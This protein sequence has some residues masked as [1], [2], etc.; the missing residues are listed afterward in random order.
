[1]ALQASGQIKY[2]EIIAEFGTSNSGGIGEYRLSESVGT[3]TN[4]PLDIGVPQTGQIKFSDF[5]SK[6]LNQVVDLYST[7]VNNTSRQNAKDR[8][9]NGNVHVVGSTKTGK[10]K[11][12][13]TIDDRVIINLNAT[14]S[15]VKGTQTHCAL[16][17]GNW[18]TGTS[19]EI[20]IGTSGK[21][22]GSGG[23]G[24]TGGSAN[25][26]PGTDGQT[27]SSALG[28]QYPCTINNL[29]VIQSGYGGGGGGGGNTRTTGGG[30][31]SGAVTN[32]SSGGGGG[33][34]AGLPAGAG[35]GVQTPLAVGGGSAGSGGAAGSLN[36]QSPGGAGGSEAGTG[37]NS[38]PVN[39]TATKAD[40]GGVYSVDGSQQ[41]ANGGIGGNNGFAIITNQ[42]SAPSVTGGGSITGRIVTSTNPT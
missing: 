35:G 16:R 10:T 17:T 34:G 40:N 33:G 21:L 38:S 28:I 9:N 24:G 14:I 23:D 39:N 15:S 32:G 30:K 7:S 31:K 22:Y 3:L 41:S 25:E 27:G 37:G 4:L 26:T 8:W 11:P 2:S 5:Y 13:N 6:R 42:G 19:L 18:D 20:E 36:G 12:P 29:G 1:M